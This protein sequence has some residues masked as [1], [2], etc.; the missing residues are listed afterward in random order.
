MSSNGDDGWSVI[1]TTTAGKSLLSN[2]KIDSYSR[3]YLYQTI[4]STVSLVLLLLFGLPRLAA[5][6]CFAI[7]LSS[8]GQWFRKSS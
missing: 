6:G 1:S 2:V 3:M 8:F 7:V 4:P 5:V